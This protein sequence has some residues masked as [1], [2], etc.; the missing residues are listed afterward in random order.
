[1]QHDIP[2]WTCRLW[3]LIV[4]RLRTLQSRLSWSCYVIAREEISDITGA[5]CVSTHQWPNLVKPINVHTTK[6]MKTWS[7][8]FMTVAYIRPSYMKHSISLNRSSQKQTLTSL[9][10][11]FTTP[12]HTNQPIKRFKNVRKILDELRPH[13]LC[14]SATTRYQ[15]PCC[16][17][18]WIIHPNSTVPIQPFWAGPESC[19]SWTNGRQSGVSLACHGSRE[20][21]VESLDH[22]HCRVM[23][24]WTCRGQA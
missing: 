9:W 14:S 11:T 15:S 21:S 2:G 7:S 6:I 18:G 5:T 1:M 23:R 16:V 17:D 13:R 3:G 10:A 19:V 24:G 4:Y 20:R 22:P 8:P 12:W